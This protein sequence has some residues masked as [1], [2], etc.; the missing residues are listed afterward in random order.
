[1]ENAAPDNKISREKIAF[2]V[3]IGIGIVFFILLLWNL[4]SGESLQK[5]RQKT[6]ADLIDTKDI[7]TLSVTEF[8]YNGIAQSLNGNGEPDYN[9]LYNSTV[10]VSVDAEG[11]QYNVDDEQKIIKFVFP[12]FKIEP[13]V[14]DIESISLIPNRS[15]LHMDDIIALCRSDAF[16]EA[17]KS[18]KLITSAQDNLKSIMEAW[19]A[20]ILRG[21]RFEYQF[22]SAEGGE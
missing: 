7:S 11:I 16:D 12:E 15:D 5:A 3:L 17:K 4:F 14:I 10:E 19:Y 6:T 2:F 9:A 20:P 1:M 22:T 13:P 18:E 8:V 21:Y